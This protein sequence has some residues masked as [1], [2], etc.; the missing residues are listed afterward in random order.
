M[1][2]GETLNCILLSE[3]IQHEKA[4]YHMIPIAL[5]SEKGKT[6]EAGKRS[7]VARI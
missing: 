6:I 5:H 2:H 4:T 1:R 3:R 7:V